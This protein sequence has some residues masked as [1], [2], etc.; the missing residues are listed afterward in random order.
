MQP[1][2]I[3]NSLTMIEIKLTESLRFILSQSNF[4]AK[5]KGQ[6]NRGRQMEKRNYTDRETQYIHQ[7]HKEVQSSTKTG[8]LT[9]VKGISKYEDII[10]I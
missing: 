10:Y 9:K 6:S 7:T 8:S 3:C 4:L 2:T 1:K 5:L